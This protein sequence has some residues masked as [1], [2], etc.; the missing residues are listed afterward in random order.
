MYWQ[1]V[2]QPCTRE[3]RG[4]LYFDLQSS[5]MFLCNGQEWEHWAW[6]VGAGSRLATAAADNG[7]SDGSPGRAVATLA[8]PIGRSQAMLRDSTIDAEVRRHGVPPTTTSSVK[9]CLPG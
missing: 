9:S 4:L 6:G 3:T 5:K 7:R 8:S 2:P 1:V